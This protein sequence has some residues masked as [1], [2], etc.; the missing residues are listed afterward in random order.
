RCARYVKTA[1]W[2]PFTVLT[3]EARPNTGEHYFKINKKNN[4]KWRD[5]TGRSNEH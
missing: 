1:S 4:V 2:R 5:S 3:K